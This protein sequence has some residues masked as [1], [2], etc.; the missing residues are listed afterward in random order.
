MGEKKYDILKHSSDL[1]IKVVGKTPEELL[2]NSAFAVFDLMTDLNK[3]EERESLPLE[4]EGVD[5]DDL[6]VNWVRELLYLFQVSGYLLKGFEIEEV[7]DHRVRARVRGE[8]FNPDTHEIRR[9]L[10]SVLY[11]QCRMEKT[12]NQWIARVTFEI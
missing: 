4:A 6:I 7:K 2:S 1:T 12:G 8:K 5:R 9:E 11:Q 10:R 3:V